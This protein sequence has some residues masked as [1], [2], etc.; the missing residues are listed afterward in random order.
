MS[1]KRILISLSLLLFFSTLVQAN[2]KEYK[3]LYLK[4]IKVND[5]T[6]GVIAGVINYVCP[7][8]VKSAKKICNLKDPVGSAVGVLF[9]AVRSQ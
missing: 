4:K 5:A 9:L 8:L 3:K 6:I 2:N 1:I 7:K